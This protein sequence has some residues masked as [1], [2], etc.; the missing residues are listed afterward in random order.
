MMQHQP[1]ESEQQAPDSSGLVFDTQ[2]THFDEQVTVQVRGRELSV[3]L[4]RVE[5]GVAGDS[6]DSPDSSVP[7]RLVRHRLGNNGVG[8]P[9]LHALFYALAAQQGGTQSAELYSHN[10]TT[11]ELDRVVLDERKIAKLHEELNSILEGIESGYFPP[12]LTPTSV[13]LPV[14]VNLPSLRPNCLSSSTGPEWK[15]YAC[16]SE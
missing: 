12:D 14:P 6:P 7:L 8:K 3:V 16:R 15:R 10:L 9:D 11:G 5:R 13:E 2:E 1:A 4:D